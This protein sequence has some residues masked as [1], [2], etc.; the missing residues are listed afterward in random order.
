M[1]PTPWGKGKPCTSK[2]ASSRMWPL[3]FVVQHGKDKNISS[4]IPHF[5]ILNEDYGIMSKTEGCLIF[6]HLVLYS[7]VV[8]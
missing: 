3:S 5:Q 6:C 2:V 8:E 7:S 4:A 1:L